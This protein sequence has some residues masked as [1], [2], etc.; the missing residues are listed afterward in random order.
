MRTYLAIIDF[1]DPSGSKNGK[2]P[3]PFARF[4]GDGARFPIEQRI[5]NKKRGIGRQT[6]PFVA[7]TLTAAMVGVLIYELVYNSRQQGSPLSFKASIY[8]TPRSKPENNVF[9]L[10]PFVNPMLGPSTTGLITLGL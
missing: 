6:Y 5:E 9:Y 10:Q 2:K 4:L 7:W 1:A 3:S 8:T